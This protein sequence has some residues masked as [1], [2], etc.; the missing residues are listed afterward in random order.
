MRHTPVAHFLPRA[1]CT[2][3]QDHTSMTFATQNSVS[4]SAGTFSSLVLK[5]AI[6]GQGL[7]LSIWHPSVFN[8][9]VNVLDRGPRCGAVALWRLSAILS[10]SSFF[11]FSGWQEVGTGSNSL[12]NPAPSCIVGFCS[13]IYVLKD[14]GES[15]NLSWCWAWSSE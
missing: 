6:L 8:I 10:F 5:S 11:F 15:A 12:W 7:T 9:L 4:V 14:A 1:A 13:R 3:E 2:H